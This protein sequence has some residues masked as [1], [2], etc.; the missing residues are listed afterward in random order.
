MH[1]FSG[2]DIALFTGFLM[3]AITVVGTLT[4]SSLDDSAKAPPDPK[5]QG[6]IGRR[7]QGIT[8]PAF[9]SFRTT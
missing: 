6:N 4:G 8:S 9:A 5:I 2:P 7:S 3:F 1:D